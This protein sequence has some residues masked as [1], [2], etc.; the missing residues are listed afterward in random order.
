MAIVHKGNL[1]IQ[2]CPS[3][4]V[5]QTFEHLE[6]LVKLDNTH[7]RFITI[8]RPPPSRANGL[9]VSSFFT[10]WSLFLE[11]HSTLPGNL[12]ITGDINL[13]LDKPDN[14]DTLRFMN[15]INTSGIL[16]HV[17]QATH[18]RGHIL[19]VVLSDQSECVVQ[20]VSVTDPGVCDNNGQLAGDH[21]AVTFTINAARPALQTKQVSYRKLKSIDVDTF[22]ADLASIQ[23]VTTSGSDLDD[24]VIAYEG[25]CGIVDKYAPLKQ[26]TLTL[27]FM[28]HGTQKDFATLNTKS[29]S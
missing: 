20:D 25:L 28:L 26:K 18:R 29:A 7:I 6:C 23:A 8:Y 17:K 3:E 15:L 24:L 21:L 12:V 10:E 4:Q 1:N 14:T 27:R 2:L 9:T 22:R 5:Y 19:D 11:Q 13:H 16:Q